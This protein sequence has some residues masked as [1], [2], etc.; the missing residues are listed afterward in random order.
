MSRMTISSIGQF[1][2]M[3]SF[4]GVA[5]FTFARLNGLR[6][7]T[8]NSTI[9][10][11]LI[12]S[13]C[14]FFAAINLYGVIHKLT[15]GKQFAFEEEIELIE[16]FSSIFFLC[17]LILVL[18]SRKIIVTPNFRVGRVLA[19]GAHPDDIEIAAGAALSKMRDS[20]YHITGLILTRG[21]AGGHIE[22]RPSEARLGAEFLGLDEVKVLALSDKSLSEDVLK[23]TDAIEVM[24]EETQ[25]DIIFTHSNHDYHQDHQTVFEATMRATRN[26]RVTILAYESPSASQDFRPT[27]FMDITKY[28]DVKIQSVRKHWD[29]HKKPYVKAELIRGKMAFRGGQAK[30]DFAEA[31]E[32]VRMISAI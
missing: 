29:Q 9:L 32:V 21:E 18:I 11:Y 25:P 26:A 6:R 8:R 2:A 3:V 17:V 15:G 16:Q 27:Y 23:A 22:V 4:I 12:I 13:I 20:G 19:I 1:I 5:I 28:V 31:F 10:F 14:L 30:V 7:T 24:I